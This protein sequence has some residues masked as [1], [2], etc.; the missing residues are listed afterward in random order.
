MVLVDKGSTIDVIFC[1]TLQGMNIDLGK[2]VPTPKP[3]TSFSGTTSMTLGSIKLPFIAKGVTKIIDFAVVDHPAI[4]NVIMGTTWINSMK[5]VPS[6]YHICRKFPT[7]KGTA[8]IWVC[9]KQS[10]LCFLAEFKLQKIMTTSMAKPKRTK[11]TR[12]SNESDLEKIIQNHLLKQRLQNRKAIRLLSQTLQSVRKNQT[13][14]K[15]P[16][17]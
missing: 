13:R 11:I 10:R 16:I 2:V 5:A 8:I 1:G 12:L 15:L 14:K 7:P 6:T 17:Q 9:Q 4:Y 3:L